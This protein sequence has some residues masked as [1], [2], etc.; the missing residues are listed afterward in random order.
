MP[1]QREETVIKASLDMPLPQAPGF[2]S[3]VREEKPE[4][5][6]AAPSKMSPEERAKLKSLIITQLDRGVL[7]D[8]LHVDL[9]DGLHGEWIRRDGFERDKM[10]GLG[11]R[12]GGEYVKSRSLHHD[13]VTPGVADVIFM[14]CDRERKEL[15]DEV[16]VEMTQRNYGSA[17]GKNQKEEKEFASGVQQATGGIVPTTIESVSREA[18]KNEIAEALGRLNSQTL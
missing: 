2:N 8:R 5:K 6:L 12:D 18:S 1:E 3:P 11:F 15:I 4:P 14:V 10:I 7:H 16:K 17:R 13:G 9:P